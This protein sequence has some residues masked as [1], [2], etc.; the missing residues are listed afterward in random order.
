MS[1]TKQTGDLRVGGDLAVKDDVSITDTLAV[2]GITTLSEDL[3]RHTHT[4]TAATAS[5][6][7]YEYPDEGVIFLDG[8][9]GACLGHLPSPTAGK[10]VTFIYM[11]SGITTN[12]IG[13]GCIS[14]N[15]CLSN[16]GA[17]A[18]LNRSW[19]ALMKTAG[20]TATFAG[21]SGIW[22]NMA[23]GAGWITWEAA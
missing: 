6:W 15:F 12:V 22:Y 19:L 1:I 3:V 14:G 5:A 8:T 13:S 16:T 21:Y 10:V 2:A 18:G 20:A 11:G 23:S 4:L 7:T 17:A 9:A